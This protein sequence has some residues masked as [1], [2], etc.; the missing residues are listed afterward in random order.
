MK[1]LSIV[2]EIVHDEEKFAEYRAAVMPSLQAHGGR[3]LARGGHFDVIEGDMPYQRVV[4]I[5]FP[6]REAFD[7]WYNSPEYQA[8]IPIRM[9]AADSL[10]VT[11]DAV[12]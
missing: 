3:F 4:V 12:E 2:Y 7:G 5:E 6:S 10:F 1:V 11:V 9:G 8:V